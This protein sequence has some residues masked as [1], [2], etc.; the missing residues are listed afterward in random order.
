M[1][2]IRRNEPCPCGSGRKYK[3]C[4]MNSNTMNACFQKHNN[5]L[6][7]HSSLD[8]PK[9]KVYMENHDCT[10]ILDYLIALQLRPEN[11]GKNL[12]IEH[13]T[14]LAV[15]CLGKSRKAPDISVFKALIDEEYPM[16]IMEDLPT[17][18]FAELVTFYGGNYVFFQE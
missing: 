8:A 1:K 14:Q 17:N 12:R 11:H 3:H 18:M 13:I 6:L 2:K 5:N 9:L 16:D 7:Q 4:C 15:S 10:R